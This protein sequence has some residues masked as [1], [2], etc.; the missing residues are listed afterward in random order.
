MDTRTTSNRALALFASALLLRT[1]GFSDIR[2]SKRFREPA[3][4]LLLLGLSAAALQAQTFRGTIAGTV[5]DTTGAAV[6]GAQVVAVETSTGAEHKMMSTGAGEFS[7][8]DL[9]LGAYTVTVTA[10]GFGTSKIDKVPVSAGVVY[11]LPVKLSIAQA[12]TTV[13]VSA[14]GLSLDTT[15]TTQTTVLP[16]TTV[17]NT[18]MNGRDFTQ[19]ISVS[20]GYAGYSAGGFGSV[21]GARANQ[22]NWQIDGS[23]NND[24]WHNIPAVNQ[25]GVEGIAGVTLP[26]DSIEEFS[27]QTQSNAESGRNPGATVNVVTKSGTNEIHG[28]LYYFNR[29]ELFAANS[30]FATPDANGQVQKN[31]LRNQQYGASVGGPIV[32][33]KFF[34]FFNYEKQQF[35]IESPASA[36]EPSTAY[37][38]NAEAL[39]AQYGIPVN[40]VQLTVLNTLFP[41]Y[42]LTGSAAADN[43]S[44]ASPITGYSYNGVGKLDWQ[45]NEN[46]RLSGRAYGGQGSQ[47][48][49]VGVQLPYYFEEGPIHV[50]NYSTVLNTVLSPRLTNQVLA[51]VNVFNQVFYDQNHTFNLAALGLN[52][53][54]GSS[55]SGAPALTISGFDNLADATPPSGRIDITG[56]ITDTAAYSVGKHEFRFGGEYRNARVHELY[57]RK[58]RGLFDYDGSQGPWSSTGGTTGAG[59]CDSLATKSITQVPITTDGPT[60]ALA[61]YLA[62]CALQ[63]GITVGDTVR[64]VYVNTYDLFLE[65]AWQLTAHLNLNYGARYDYLGPMHDAGQDLSIFDPSIS[66][67]TVPGIAVQGAQVANLWQAAHND[68]SPRIGFS[69]NPPSSP[70]LV[71]RG[72]FGVF[73][74]EPNLNP[75]LDN[76]PP[77]N[78]ASGAETMPAG[79]IPVS[80]YS[81]EDQVIPSNGALLFP[82]TGVF[83]P[84]GLSPSGTPLTTGALSNPYNLFSVSPNFRSAY[85]YNYN[86]NVE[87]K[88][89][90]NLLATLGYVGSQGRKEL[91]I[92]DINQAALGSSSLG[93]FAQDSTRPYGA[94]FPYYGVINQIDSAGTSNYNSLQAVIRTT[95][96]HG[97]TSQ[98]AYTWSHGLDELTQ[99]RNQS[100][101]NSF[102]LKA[103]YG[104][105]DYD[106]RN[107]FVTYLNYAFPGDIP[108]PHWLTHGWQ[109]NGLITL[110]GGQPYTVYTGMD[111]SGTGEGEDRVDQVGAFVKGSRQIVDHSGSLSWF[112]NTNNSTFSV[113]SNL[114]GT[115]RRNQL[116]SPGYE[117]VDFSVFKDGH[118][119]ERIAAQFRVEM[120]NLLNHTNLAPPDSSYSD[121][122]FGNITTTI[123]NYNGAPGIGPGEP[124]NTQFALKILF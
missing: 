86:L 110:H 31:E 17:Q 73:F 5:T 81:F 16:T 76:R 50:Y 80:N 74:D 79:K 54:V 68:V 61:D 8:A 36:T 113:P 19:L 97:L 87:Q 2:F 45:I 40:P 98:F 12:A 116:F 82:T 20:P 9:P 62:G 34:Y 24:L 66:G 93:T 57:R 91:I 13:E 94:E 23:D 15:S 104:N 88:L 35:I 115:M 47:I 48:A 72:G 75:F 123:G 95:N 70:D 56:L 53:G 11:T 51:G 71:L 64:Q 92:R 105:M 49:P 33:D 119:T 67:E 14:A 90:P 96:L 25:G 4:M 89:G 26:L 121:G 69:Y 42:A 101:Q 10:S 22:N 106:T 30:P 109:L 108:G 6:P 55:L 120:F 39:L 99:Y 29:N 114:F 7:F 103:D 100:P 63:D 83:A 78:G 27:Q 65:D 84:Y 32:K 107:A 37:Q 102:D 41:A 52:T 58:E 111:S 85:N 124:F 60:Q 1:C 28:S 21:N 112:T 38:A 77:N 117:D 59:S 46:N 18:P 118:I 43:Y 3:A 44:N 122:G